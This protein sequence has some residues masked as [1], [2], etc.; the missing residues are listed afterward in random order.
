MMQFQLVHFATVE[1]LTSNTHYLGLRR[2]LVCIKWLNTVNIVLLCHTMST[3]EHVQSPVPSPF[4]HAAGVWFLQVHC[5]IL[6]WHAV[7]DTAPKKNLAKNNVKTASP[8]TCLKIAFCQCLSKNLSTL[9][10]HGHFLQGKYLDTVT[11]H[12]HWSEEDFISSHAFP[13]M[14]PCDTVNKMAGAKLTN[15]NT[16][17]PWVPRVLNVPF[18]DQTKGPSTGT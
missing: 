8:G 15:E 13:L 3:W 10:W 18:R 16:A 1:S 17:A 6:G 11:R 7:D 14:L 5:P 4:L 12:G 2:G 9:P